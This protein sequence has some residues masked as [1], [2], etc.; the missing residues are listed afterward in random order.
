LWKQRAYRWYRNFIR[1]LFPELL[2]MLSYDQGSILGNVLFR[3][4]WVHRWLYVYAAMSLPPFWAKVR[5]QT[6]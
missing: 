6:S 1:R 3:L 4:A 5:F 2:L